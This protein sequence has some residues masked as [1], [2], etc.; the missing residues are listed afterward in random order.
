MLDGKH[1]TAFLPPNI[2]YIGH[3]TNVGRTVLKLFPRTSSGNRHILD[4]RIVVCEF[5]RASYSVPISPVSPGVYP[6]HTGAVNGGKDEF[7]T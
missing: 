4:S 6:T 2:E 7:T 1:A 5:L 3:A